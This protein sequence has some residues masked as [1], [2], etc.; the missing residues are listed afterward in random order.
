MT[1][2]VSAGPYT[3]ELPPN[4]VAILYEA[5]NAGIDHQLAGGVGYF[6]ALVQFAGEIIRLN[7]MIDQMQVDRRDGDLAV[8]DAISETARTAD[9]LA[10]WRYQAIWHRSMMMHGK[11]GPGQ[12]PMLEGTRY[13]SDAER[14]LEHARVAENRERYA[15]AEA[16]RD[17][18]GT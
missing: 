4:G 12:A 1:R 14:D 7:A 3:L 2:K 17:P 15:H 13:W 8:R 5:D 16:P 10:F 18:G 6:E 9:E 11:P